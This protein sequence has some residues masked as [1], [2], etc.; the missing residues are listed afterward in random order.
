MQL[1]CSEEQQGERGRE[2]SSPTNTA[3]HNTSVGSPNKP[4]AKKSREASGLRD[5]S[6]MFGGKPGH[7]K[8]IHGKWIPFSPHTQR[9]HSAI[10]FVLK[11]DHIPQLEAFERD[12]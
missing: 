10:I 2:L 9:C 8:A 4:P 1:R 3:L 5:F 12:G 11:K 7:Q 6:F